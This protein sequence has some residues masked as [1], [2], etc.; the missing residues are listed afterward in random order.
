M[1]DNKI[2]NLKKQIDILNEENRNLKE[3]LKKCRPADERLR[4]IIE[5]SE[6]AV[7]D[8]LIPISYHLYYCPEFAKILGFGDDEIF[9]LNQEI[10]WF[11]NRIHKDDYKKIQPIIDD[12]KSGKIDSSHFK[13]RFLSKED[14]WIYLKIYC[15]VKE[16][17]KNEIVR[18]LAVLEDIT[19]QQKID[20]KLM[21]S[22]RRYH[23]IFE[24]S[25]LSLWEEDWSDVKKYLNKLQE[26]GVEDF[27]TYFQEHPQA[28]SKCISLVKILDV[29]KRTLQ[30]HK[31]HNK[32][33]FLSN[34]SLVF[35]DSSEKYFIDEL[36]SFANGK[37][38]YE[39]ENIHRTLDGDILNIKLRMN[40]VP[41]YEKNLSKVIV[42]MMDITEKKKIEKELEEL[43]TE[44][45][46]LNKSHQE[47]E[48][49]ISICLSCNKVK[50]DE[51]FN[52]RV[53]DYLHRHPEA[54]FI[55][56]VCSDCR[57][58]LIKHSKKE[59]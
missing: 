37:T 29:N 12:L 20:I 51:D 46:A 5:S 24:N 10:D 26:N 2:E 42:S 56:Y 34:L 52:N 15:I 45:E 22:E 48:S 55:H 40:V 21:S 31:A 59:L 1:V 25:P 44:Y 50:I 43:K 47:L 16:R 18:I 30:M 58:K 28:V 19:Q 7:I 27:E 32:N 57:E 36:V 38:T 35:T 54:E 39:A 3:E 41:G 53:L 11:A 6:I 33:V 49:A 14:K 8:Y 23:G 4:S 13:I 17:E 9:L